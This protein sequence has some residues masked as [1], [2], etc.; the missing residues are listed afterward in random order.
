MIF[1]V[2]ISRILWKLTL[3]DLC[4]SHPIKI[5]RIL[6]TNDGELCL[7]DC[8]GGHLCC[9]DKCAICSDLH[10]MAQR[11]FLWSRTPTGLFVSSL[12]TRPC[13]KD[14]N[15]FTF[16]SAG[17]MTGTLVSRSKRSK[18]SKYQCSALRRRMHSRSLSVK[19]CLGQPRERRS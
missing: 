7:L 8:C 4:L 14:K 10:P 3:P 13:L 19:P 11:S 1:R 18:R 16:L 12:I 17:N 2:Q 9:G 6:L 15:Y 5:N